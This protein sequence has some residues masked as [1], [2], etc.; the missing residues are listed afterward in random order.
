MD[1]SVERATAEDRGTVNFQVYGAG[2][3]ATSSWPMEIPTFQVSCVPNGASRKKKYG[4][5]VR[6]DTDPTRFVGRS[7]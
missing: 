3:S 5:A 2:E 6:L 1:L 4:R 7:V